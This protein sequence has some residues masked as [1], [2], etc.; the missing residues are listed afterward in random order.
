[1]QREIMILKAHLF[2]HFFLNV[3][4][5]NGNYIFFLENGLLVLLYCPRK[6]Y[7]IKNMHL[8]VVELY[9][10]QEFFQM[11]KPHT[12][13]EIF[14]REGL[15]NIYLLH[16]TLLI[17]LTKLCYPCVNKKDKSRNW[18]SHTPVKIH[19]P[20]SFS[21]ALYSDAAYT[22]RVVPSLLLFLCC[23]IDW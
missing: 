7:A 6:T 4:Y 12:N 14:I 21:Y 23:D 2:Y 19:Q 20:A 9:T 8:C 13:P 1:M 3:L 5:I 10:M 17:L 11:S 15:H 18:G 16:A 22:L